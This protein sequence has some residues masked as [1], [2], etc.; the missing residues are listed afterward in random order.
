VIVPALEKSED[1]SEPAVVVAE[2]EAESA[3][4]HVVSVLEW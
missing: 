2:A 3:E 4:T 1:D